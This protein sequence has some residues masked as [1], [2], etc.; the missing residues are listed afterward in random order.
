ML[1]Q[2][3]KSDKK[4]HHIFFLSNNPKSLVSVRYAF[5]A[6]N[7]FT[8]TIPS[9]LGN[10]SPS[11]SVLHLHQNL[12]EGTI[13]TELG[14]LTHLS[15]LI[16][17]N[18]TLK[19]TVPST[20][21]QLQDMYMLYLSH[22]SDLSGT[23]PS[24]LSSLTSLIALDIKNTSIS[25]TLPEALQQAAQNMDYETFFHDCGQGYSEDCF[26]ETQG[27]LISNPWQFM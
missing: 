14:L 23:L 18:N 11:A 21:G 5:L 13:A 20:L 6:A 2:S 3:A 7:H 4:S 15:E 25:G 8:G 9:V 26:A 16:L 22:N 12:L 27:R 17:S 19:G 1:R 10:L 24:E